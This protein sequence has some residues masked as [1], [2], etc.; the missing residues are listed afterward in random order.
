MTE[1]PAALRLLPQ[2]HT[3]KSALVSLFQEWNT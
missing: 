1:Q 3:L 2:E